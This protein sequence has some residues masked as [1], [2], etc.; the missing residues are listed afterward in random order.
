[1]SECHAAPEEVERNKRVV[2]NEHGHEA[3]NQNTSN[4]MGIPSNGILQMT[5]TALNMNYIFILNCLIATP[6]CV[7]SI[8]FWNCNPDIGEC[9]T[10]LI[11]YKIILPLSFIIISGGIFIFFYKLKKTESF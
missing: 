2:N 6:A 11:V 4:A 9:E 1:M 8:V 3:Q 5:K 7:A 10:F